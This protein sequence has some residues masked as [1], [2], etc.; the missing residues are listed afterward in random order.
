MQSW[1]KQRECKNETPAP[2]CSAPEVGNLRRRPSMPSLNA[3]MLEVA[4][5]DLHASPCIACGNPGVFV[6]VWSPSPECIAKELG[7]DPTRF[8]RLVYRLCETC[9]RRGV[10]DKR[11][12]AIVEGKIL[13]LW[14]AG[15]VHRIRD[16][17]SIP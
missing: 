16:G 17:V 4:A 7:G 6:A 9:G 11:F 8:R 13:R 12:V 15:R 2:S 10:H 1:S 3:L 5:E 14:R